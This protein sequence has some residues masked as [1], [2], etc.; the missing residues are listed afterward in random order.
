MDA[1]HHGVAGFVKTFE[2]EIVAGAE[3]HVKENSK[4]V[5]SGP[6]GDYWRPLVAGTHELWAQLGV[7]RSKTVEVT[8]SDKYEV[9]YNFTLYSQTGEWNE[10]EHYVFEPPEKEEPQAVKIP[11]NHPFTL[12]Y[13]YLIT[14]FSVLYSIGIYYLLCGISSSL[15][16]IVFLDELLICYPS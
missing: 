12:P 1:V 14:S 8:V 16:S 6:D 2:G 9:V 11:V 7:L 13:L 3:I 15:L 5:K 10:T 4:T